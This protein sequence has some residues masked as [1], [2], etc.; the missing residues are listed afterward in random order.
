MDDN[1]NREPHLPRKVFSTIMFVTQIAWIIL[2]PI[3]MCLAL[4][5][6][7]D[8]KW[9]NG[10]RTYTLI[11]ILIG[12]VCAIRNGYMLFRGY[13]RDINKKNAENYK[14]DINGN[15]ERH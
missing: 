7:A 8:S 13:I 12:V 2:S 6:V 4:G 1:E 10:N 3:V 9:G 5:Y 14:K 11:G 15:D